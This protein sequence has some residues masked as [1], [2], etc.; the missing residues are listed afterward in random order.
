M[1][2]PMELGA[3]QL[4]ERF[5]SSTTGR[6]NCKLAIMDSEYDKSVDQKKPPVRGRFL[7][8]MA[9]KN[10]PPPLSEELR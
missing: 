4:T 10:S 7:S 2:P 5:Q 3:N 8:I 1:I 6:T 9:A